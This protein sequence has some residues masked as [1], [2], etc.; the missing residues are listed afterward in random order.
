MLLLF[1]LKLSN[2]SR[3]LN[4]M[5]CLNM[6]WS[7]KIRESNQKRSTL[8]IQH[9]L[10]TFRFSLLPYVILWCFGSFRVVHD[11]SKKKRFN[12]NVHWMNNNV[13]MMSC[14]AFLV[15]VSISSQFIIYRN[16]FD[17]KWYP[18]C[19]AMIIVKR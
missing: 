2:V 18:L 5:E 17:L 3:K 13:L 4:M 16:F 11:H 19:Y 14:D 1:D 8:N 7:Q 9:L 12:N 6:S 15:S 10:K